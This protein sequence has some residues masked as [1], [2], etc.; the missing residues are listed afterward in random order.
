MDVLKQI[1]E[2]RHL[3][4]DSGLVVCVLPSW[5]AVPSHHPDR[6]YATFCE[7]AAHPPPPIP[8]PPALECLIV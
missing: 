8:V 3:F 4:L 7:L 6:H 2:V 1:S 5:W